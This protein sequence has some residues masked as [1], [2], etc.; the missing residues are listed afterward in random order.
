[1]PDLYTFG[2]AM[3]LFLASDTDSVLT[4]RTYTRSTAGAEG[5]VAVGVTRLGLS[6]HFFTLM[7]NDQ[8]G[9]AVLADFAAEGVDVSGVKRVDS[10]SSAMIRNP[11]TTAPVEAS[12]LRKGAAASLMTPADLDQQVIAQSRW[13][14][15]TGITCAISSSAAQTVSAGLESA[16]KHGIKK[17]FDLNIRRKLWSEE[18]ARAVLEPIARDVDLLI[19]GED[20]YCAIFGSSDGEE[21]LRIAASRNNSVAIMTKGPE[22]LTY[23]VNG[24]FTTVH[25]P[26]VKSVD[27]VGSGDAFTSGVIS[28]LL[29]G[30]S[31]SDAVAQG[32][33]SGARVASQFGDWA[34]LPSGKGGVTEQRYIDEILGKAR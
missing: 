23:A 14:H 16:R 6:A 27:P 21:A 24:A 28:G 18:E 5:N 4:A 17:S 8:L 29:A 31:V 1:M 26:Q 33:I 7:G 30:L 19:G 13:L 12:Y 20:E 11:G 22:Q 32:T 25:P 9:S 2:E 10:F 15:T 34:G 3:A